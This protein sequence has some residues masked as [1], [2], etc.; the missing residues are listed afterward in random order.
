MCK[1][2][3]SYSGVSEVFC[4]LKLFRHNPE[5]LN[6]QTQLVYGIVALKYS[7]HS[8]SKVTHACC[9]SYPFQEAQNRITKLYEPK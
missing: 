9:F 5:D 1:I 2:W 6:S 8:L 3:G 4:D 7:S